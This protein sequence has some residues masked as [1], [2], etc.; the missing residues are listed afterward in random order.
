MFVVC[1]TVHVIPGFAEAFITATEANVRGTR[2]ET[3][4]VRFDVLR[5]IDDE[6]RFFLYE[7]YKTPEDFASHQQTAHYLEW[8][9]TVADWMAEKR[10]GLKHTSVFPAEQDW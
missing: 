4:N 2:Q 5:G 7:V 1:V 3:G 8:R 10:V 9:E 6:N